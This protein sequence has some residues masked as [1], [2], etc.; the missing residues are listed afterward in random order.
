MNGISPERL[1]AA[2]NWR[3][4]ID[5]IDMEHSKNIYLLYELYRESEMK[6]IR[7][8]VLDKMRGGVAE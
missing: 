7:A 8:S 6:Q 3:D 1:C 4:G 2:E 5:M